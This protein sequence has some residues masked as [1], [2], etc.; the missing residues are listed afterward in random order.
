MTAKPRAPKK[1]TGRYG[2]EPKPWP[3]P[4]DGIELLDALVATFRRYLAL[5]EGAAETLA[6]W[7]VFTHA[8][9]ASA[10]APRLAILSPIPRCGK[11][12]LISLLTRLVR[13]P[14]AASNATPA[15]IFRRIDQ[16]QSTLLIDEADTF[17]IGRSE[18]AGIVNSGHARD[19]AFV[20]RCE[21]DDHHVH[22]FGTYAAI[23]IAK[24]GK[25]PAAVQDRSIVIHMQRRRPDERV[26]RFRQDRVASLLELKRKV[27]RWVTSNLSILKTADPAI[28]EGLNDR[29]ADNWRILVTIADA[30]GGH[31]PETARRVAVM[32][33]G[34]EEDTSLSAQL[35]HD[36]ADIFSTLTVD[37]ISSAELRHQLECREDR[38]WATLSE[39]EPIGAYRLATMLEPFGIRPKVLRIGD[40][41][42]RGYDR[43]QFAD[44]WE[45]YPRP[46]TATPQQASQI[47]GLR[48]DQTATQTATGSPESATGPAGVADQPGDVADHVAVLK[49]KRY[50]K[51]NNV[52]AVAV[53][54]GGASKGSV[55]GLD[56]PFPAFPSRRKRRNNGKH[57]DD[58]DG[59]D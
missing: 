31:W 28:P 9:D 12:T 5:R 27:I 3:K 16:D 43:S 57:R 37:R 8:I 26:D 48:E 29:A 59:P 58:H 32:I 17:F 19:T 15:A 50:N 25:L 23:A 20:L 21:G 52:A 56:T 30:A 33:S 36:I 2:V 53:P 54:R 55:I 13:R 51:I 7:L 41:T 35:L 47:N 1:A 6:L 40:K 44:A 10:V 34:D 42:P 39:G 22:S 14:L 45:R 18:L 4:V 49:G 24:I 11:T 46:Q 38:P